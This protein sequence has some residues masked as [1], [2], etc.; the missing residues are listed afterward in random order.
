MINTVGLHTKAKT[1][2][3]GLVYDIY[4]HG[5][6]DHAVI[7][8]F[9]HFSFLPPNFSM[10]LALVGQAKGSHTHVYS[11]STPVPEFPS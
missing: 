11:N 1:K 5:L 4:S 9:F 6:R 3:E 8:F 2:E 7:N 10:Y